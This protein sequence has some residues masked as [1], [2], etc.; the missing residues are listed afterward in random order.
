MISPVFSRVHLHGLRLGKDPDNSQKT[1]ENTDMEN[2]QI[3]FD[4]KLLSEIDCPV[5]ATCHSV[6]WM[7]DMDD[8]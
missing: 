3:S 6:E 1:K 8:L 2:I 4:E 7:I 5:S